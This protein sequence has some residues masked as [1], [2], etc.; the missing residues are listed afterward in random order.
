MAYNEVRG[1]MPEISRFL[2]IIIRMYFDAVEHNPPHF[3]AYYGEHEAVFAIDILEVIK[4]KLPARV[5]GVVVEWAEMHKKE[6]KNN[7]E[8]L[9]EDKFK[10]IK[11]LV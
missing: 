5:K 8:L 3:H 11:P 10:K 4:G 2:G 1:M 6:L 7:W 9:K